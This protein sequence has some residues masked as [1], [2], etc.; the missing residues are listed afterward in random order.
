LNLGS[1]PRS[2]TGAAAT[3]GPPAPFTNHREQVQ[4]EAESADAI[5][6]ETMARLGQI[7][8]IDAA[9]GRPAVGRTPIDPNLPPD[10]PLEPGSTGR[11]RGASPLSEYVTPSDGGFRNEAPGHC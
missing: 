5:A 2:L 10:H 1:M 9:L 11:S 7:D 8:Q 4:A 6:A 3:L